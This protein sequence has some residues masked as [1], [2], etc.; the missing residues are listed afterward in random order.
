MLAPYIDGTAI[1]KAWRLIQM[2]LR[3]SFGEETYR[4]WL[5]DLTPVAIEN[6]TRVR[7]I[8]QP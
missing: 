4:Q 2:R 6:D 3:A 7:R 1:A 5:A 8:P